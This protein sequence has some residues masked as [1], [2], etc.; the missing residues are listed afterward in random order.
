MRDRNC[1]L[2]TAKINSLSSPFSLPCQGLADVLDIRHT[3]NISGLKSAPKVDYRIIWLA[4][5]RYA[6]GVLF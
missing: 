3:A 1:K 5:A 2:Q 4:H 6:F